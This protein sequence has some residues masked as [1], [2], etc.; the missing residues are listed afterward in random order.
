MLLLF[1]RLSSIEVSVIFHQVFDQAEGADCRQPSAIKLC[2]SFIDRIIVTWTAA[3]SAPRVGIEITFDAGRDSIRSTTTV[4][5]A[6]R[7]FLELGDLH[8]EIF[9]IKQVFHVLKDSVLFLFV[10]KFVTKEV[11]R[12][13]P[14]VLKLRIV[15]LAAVGFLLHNSVFL[16]DCVKAD[17]RNFDREVFN[18]ASVRSTLSF[19][20]VNFIDEDSDRNAFDHSFALVSVWLFFELDIYLIGSLSRMRQNHALSLVK[21]QD[22]SLKILIRSSCNRHGVAPIWAFL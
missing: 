10:T 6:Q 17:S 7:V 5:W 21:G 4:L 9:I 8:S 12:N 20:L 22:S 16:L 19:H 14:L 11:V 1:L 3:I 2:I 13:V 15:G 18:I